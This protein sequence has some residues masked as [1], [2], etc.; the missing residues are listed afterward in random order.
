MSNT[1]TNKNQLLL[2][3]DYGTEVIR[4]SQLYDPSNCIWQRCKADDAYVSTRTYAIPGIKNKAV[5]FD[6]QTG[7][8]KAVY[9]AS[10]TSYYY[11]VAENEGK[12]Q[13]RYVPAAQSIVVV[14]SSTQYSQYTLMVVDWVED[15]GDSDRVY[16]ALSDTAKAS[17]VPTFESHLKPI[18]FTGGV[19]QATRAVD[20]QND[21]LMLYIEE[22]PHTPVSGDSRTTVQKLIPDRKLMM[23]G[24]RPL[25]Y[26]LRRSDGSTIINTDSL[27]AGSSD[28]ESLSRYVTAMFKPV[29]VPNEEQFNELIGSVVQY[30]DTVTSTR[31]EVTVSDDATLRNTVIAS[32]KAGYPVYII[33]N[34]DDALMQVQ[35][36]E[37]CYMRASQTP[38][39]SGEIVTM[40]IYEV[41][42][43]SAT[44]RLIMSVKLHT[45]T[46]ASLSPADLKKGT[47]VG[48]DALLGNET[49]ASDV[50]SLVYGTASES[51]KSMIH[52]YL[53]LENG[54][55]QEVDVDD[56]ALKI[57][58]IEVLDGNTT[59][60]VAK[61]S[62]GMEFDILFKYF[63]YVAAGMEPTLTANVR[64]T[65]TTDTTP[66]A[67][68]QY[69]IVDRTTASGWALASADGT[70]TAFVSGTNYYEKVRTMSWDG[71]VNRPTGDFLTCRKRISISSGLSSQGTTINHITTI[72]IWNRETEGYDF[73]FL[74]YKHDY[75]VPKLITKNPSDNGYVT[76]ADA[77]P[78]GPIPDDAEDAIYYTDLF[79]K[80]NTTAAAY[81][82]SKSVL[83]SVLECK[84]SIGRENWLIG[85]DGNGTPDSGWST[86]RPPYG[87]HDTGAGLI[88]PR[89]EC[90]KETVNGKTVGKFQIPTG[91][92]PN[93]QTKNWFIDQFY[94][95][96]LTDDD[97]WSIQ[98][99]PNCFRIRAVED[100]VINGE[101][102][103]ADQI[104]SEYFVIDEGSD[105]GK[106]AYGVAFECPGIKIPTDPSIEE[107]YASD[108]DTSPIPRMPTTV[109]VEFAYSSNGQI[110][111]LMGV[112]VEVY[113][114]D[115][116]PAED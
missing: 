95:A 14:D 8:T 87:R 3:G 116:N 82:G 92:F 22:I 80:P 15:G 102:V 9:D 19:D 77:L 30:Y 96:A 61:P 114:I 29:A 52:P 45:R 112:P 46:G 23:Y 55:R 73:K 25:L 2:F 13:S 105:R 39:T 58:G 49:S 62:A 71:V 78:Y 1:T 67:N 91:V 68:K 106:M 65:P 108:E 40:D 28:T 5:F 38:L 56:D 113:R 43:G 86:A 11:Y 47:I 17:Y 72:P 111:T 64:Y 101:T 6:K 12:E 27:A 48:F 107:E 54:D 42:E 44:R 83:L 37:Y 63:P 75:S 36:P 85:G 59:A 109:I 26:V 34:S 89:L 90:W 10:P 104:T 99:E 76:G 35:L 24:P 70:L 74:V 60:G 93:L 16:A 21:R 4:L 88:R 81:S 32:Y 31:K 103:P 79:Y 53:L 84:G 94:T 115:H 41:D 50:W 7:L 97:T 20:Y 18:N 69:F 66:V 110:L 57:Y 100:G 33:T 51:L 98:V